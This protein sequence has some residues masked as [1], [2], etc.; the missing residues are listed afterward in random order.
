MPQLNLVQQAATLFVSGPQEINLCVTS[1]SEAHNSSN[2][3]FVLN[4]NTMPPHYLPPHYY[5]QTVK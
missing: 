5:K 4:S 2:S 3:D 1:T